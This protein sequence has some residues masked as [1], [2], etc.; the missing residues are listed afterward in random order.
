MESE[1]RVVGVIIGLAAMFGFLI[2]V[3]AFGA[4]FQRDTYDCTVKCPNNSHS[5]YVDEKC[6][7]EV[8]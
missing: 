7:C 5:I 6:F 1:G 8:K 3:I 4:R 2:G